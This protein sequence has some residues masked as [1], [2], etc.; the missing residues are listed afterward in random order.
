M[1]TTTSEGVPS[2]GKCQ[3][4]VSCFLPQVPLVLLVVGLFYR[5]YWLLLP[6]IFLLLIVPLLDLLTGWQDDVQFRRSDFSSA[7][8][9]LLRWNT[10]LYAIFYLAAVIF[11]LRFS[12]RLT[13]LEIGFLTLSMALLG[14]VGFG[15]AHEL[16]HERDGFDQLLQRIATLFLFYPHYK[17]IHTQSHHAHAAT[18][19]D[20]NTAW[21]DETIYGYILRTIPQSMLRCWEMEDAR[22]SK[23]TSSGWSRIFKNQMLTFGAGQLVLLAALYLLAGL[24]GLLFYLGQVIGAHI[25]LESVNYIQHY[26]LMRERSDGEYEKTGPE[27]SWDTYHYFSSYSTFRVGH[28]S[29]HHVSANPYYLLGVEPE[30]PKL[31]VG[32]FW[33]IP[34]VLVPPF[35]HRLINPKLCPQPA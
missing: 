19:H 9:F 27:H 2:Y 12:L 33:A 24:P 3:H 30:A 10:R 17:L 11:S 8:T 35:W 28:H 23:R 14:G 21:M 6:A 7:E 18:D 13:P 25:V 20:K 22:I 26:G 5:G 32:Y 31:P 1:D 29:H 15:S 16:L 4:I 34:V